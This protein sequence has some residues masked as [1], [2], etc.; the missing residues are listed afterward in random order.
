MPVPMLPAFQIPLTQV[1]LSLIGEICAIQGQI[2]YLMQ[3]AVKRW[4]V[5]DQVTIL[6]VMGSTAIR[7]NAD[8]FVKV[9]REKCKWHP[10]C[11][12]L[13]ETIFAQID[14]LAPARGGIVHPVYALRDAQSSPPSAE[15]VTPLLENIVGVRTKTRKQRSGGDIEKVRNDAA[16]ISCALAHLDWLMTRGDAPSPW[17]GKF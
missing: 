14:A 15:D 6:A 7:R 17:H 8:I 12:Q 4:L 9:A 11:L 16:R 13:A 3:S 10:E 1:E 2:D 5:I